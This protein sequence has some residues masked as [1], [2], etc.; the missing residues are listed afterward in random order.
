MKKIILVIIVLFI[1]FF[2]IAQDANSEEFDDLDSLFAEAEDIQVEEKTEAPQ[3]I[4]KSQSISFSGSLNSFFTSFCT[5][6]LMA[7]I[8]I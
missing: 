6:L 4:A 3:P 8:F 2:V 1:S 7:S 5:R